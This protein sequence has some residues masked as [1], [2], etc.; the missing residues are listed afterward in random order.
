LCADNVPNSWCRCYAI[1]FI[2]VE[3]LQTDG[4]RGRRSREDISIQRDAFRRSVAQC[5]IGGCSERLPGTGKPK[6]DWC[7]RPNHRARTTSLNEE[8][9]ECF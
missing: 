7:L 9:G 1:Q 8:I 6:C 4:S 3:L 2:G 5:E